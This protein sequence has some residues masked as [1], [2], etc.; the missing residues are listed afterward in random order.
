MK[1]LETDRLILRSWSEGDLAPMV[2]INQQVSPDV[3][4]ERI[5]HNRPLLPRTDYKAFL[6][7]LRQDRDDL[8]SQVANYSVSSDNGDIDSHVE[9]IINAMKQQDI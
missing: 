3:Q 6:N 7:T 2:A 1:P 5:G 8:Y 4:L 9:Q